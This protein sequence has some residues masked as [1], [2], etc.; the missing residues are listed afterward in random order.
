MEPIEERHATESTVDEANNLCM[1]GGWWGPGWY[2]DPFWPDFAFMP[3]FGSG[4][5]AFGY[6]FFSP[7]CVGYAPYY[8][9]GY[10]HW[11]GGYGHFFNPGG[12]GR[13]LPP[14][15]HQAR[16]G[17]AGFQ[18]FPRGMT[19]GHMGVS[20]GGFRGG[21]A[22]DFHSGMRGGFSGRSMGGFHGG[23]FGGGRR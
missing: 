6:P 13:G 7:W 17:S 20:R 8:G 18:A 22:G 1:G 23:R 5:G 10:G 9:F 3:G 19:G 21:S 4:W 15:A 16:A 2:W 11:H 14:L 12:R